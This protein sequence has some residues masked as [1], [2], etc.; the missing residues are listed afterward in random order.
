LLH[1]G[2][3][4]TG[5]VEIVEIKDHPFFIGAI[6]SRIQKYRCQSAPIF[7]NFVAAAVQAKK[8]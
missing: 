1:W 4:D 3:S 8:K 7:F 6:P 2:K 5:L